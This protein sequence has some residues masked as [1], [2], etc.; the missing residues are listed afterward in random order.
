MQPRKHRGVDL[1]QWAF[2]EVGEAY[3]WVNVAWWTNQEV[4]YVCSALHAGHYSTA[5]ALA[6]R[7]LGEHHQTDADVQ[8]QRF[9]PDC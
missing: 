5:S 6:E 1:F 7:G 3:S 9:L 2:R 4:H 8:R